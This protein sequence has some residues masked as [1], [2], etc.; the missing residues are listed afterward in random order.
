LPIWSTTQKKAA[1]TIFLYQHADLADQ[2][3]K[4]V[5]PFPSGSSLAGPFFLIST[6]SGFRLHSTPS[7]GIPTGPMR[8][9]ANLA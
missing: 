6:A 8:I 4:S 9:A 7:H 5:T 2:K 3:N 1:A